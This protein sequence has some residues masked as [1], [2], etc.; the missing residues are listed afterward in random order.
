[1][2]IL[3]MLAGAIRSSLEWSWGHKRTAAELAMAVVILIGGWRYNRLQAAAAAT[4]AQQEGLA[5]GLREQIKLTNGQLEIT[6]REVNGKIVYKRIYVP[7]EGSVVI[8][9]KEEDTMR[10][11]LADLAAKLAAA[12]AKGDTKA[13]S[14]INTEIDKIGNDVDV[15]IV[16]KGITF[17]PGYGLDW[18]NH[19]IKPRLD[20]KAFYWNRYSMLVGGG[21]NGVGPGISRHIDDIMWGHPQNVEIF[22]QWSAFTLNAGDSRYVVGL[23]SNF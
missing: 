9:Q 19:G 16:N 15:K 8:T 11:Q 6:R 10:K 12:T 20:F 18:S 22:A 3:T 13:A 4:K 17:R 5:A 7:E 14:E 21:E 23:R 1:M 2:N